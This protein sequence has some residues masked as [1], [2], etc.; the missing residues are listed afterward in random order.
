[1]SLNFFMSKSVVLHSLCLAL[2][3]AG[4]SH[5]SLT[6][7]EPVV[8]SST[9]VAS[10]EKDIDFARDVRPILADACYHCH[11]PDA[12]HREADLRLDHSEGATAD[13]GGY[14]AIVP[15][16]DERS[17]LVSRIM[18]DD[19][20]KVMPP[21]HSGK[22]LDARS[23]EVLRRWIDEGAA[24]STHWAFE[25]P[26]KPPLPSVK[27]LDWP[28]GELDTF[29][30]DRLEREGLTPSPSA[31]RETL[32]RR[33]TLDLTGLPPAPEDVDAFC[34]DP[35]PTAYEREVKRL[36][37]SVHYGERWGRIWL[38]AA[39]YADSDGFEKDKP[40]FV[41]FYR[42]WVVDSLN[43]DLPYDQ[44][45]IKQIAGDLLPNATQG[46]H[47]A[48]GFLRNSMINEEGGVDP[49]QFRMEA[50][51]DRMDAIGKSVLGLTL[52]CAQCHSHKYD[53]LTQVEYYCMFAFL[54]NSHEANI[55][56]YTD[57]EQ[58]RVSDVAQRLALI[59]DEFQAA[60]PRWKTEYESWERSVAPQSTTS[61]KPLEIRFIADSQGGQK[62]IPQGDGSY[63]AQGY[64]PTKST[65]TGDATIHSLK[66]ITG[67][68]I[69]L[70]N[71]P[72]LPHGG[73]GRSVDGTWTLSE[74]DLKVKKNGNWEKV[75]F[76]SASSTINL[77]QRPLAGRYGDKT[78]TERLVGPASFA[79]DGNSNT[80]WHGDMGPGRRNGPQTAMFI[81]AEAIA[82]KD[83][84]PIELRIGLTQNHGGWNSDD[85][86]THNLGRFRVLVCGDKSPTIDAIPPVL[87]D[88]L[89][90]V[91]LRRTKRDADRLLDFW[92]GQMP[93]WKNLAEKM[94]AAWAEHP[95]GTSQLTLVER[96]WPR[97]T[98]RLDRGSFL[99]PKEVV[100]RGTPAFL[101]SIDFQL[102]H[103]DSPSVDQPTATRL[104]FA[105]WLVS[106]KQPTT[107]RSIVN[108]VWQE[109]FGTGLTATSDDLG[110][111]GEP[112]SHP[113]LLDWLAADFMENG[114]SLKHLHQRIVLS[115]TYQQSSFVTPKLLELDPSNRLLARG[116]RRRISAEMVRDVALA[117]SGLLNRTVGGPPI[118]PPAPSFLFQPPASYGPKTWNENTDGNQYR[119]ALYT[120]RFRSVPY[121]VLQA[122]DSPTGEVSCVRRSLSNTPLQALTTLNEPLFLE[123]ARQLAKQSGDQASDKARIESIFRRCVSRYPTNDE[124]KIL[125]TLLNQQRERFAT[126]SEGASK[127]ALGASSQ[128]AADQAAWIALSRV[129]MN[130]DETI[131]K[132]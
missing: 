22:S 6:A 114:W 121:P 1:M 105:K 92:I 108:R 124:L 18:S 9:V 78:D 5:S 3:F 126:D 80:A 29:V 62:F 93:A 42:D 24:Y 115:A 40:R 116:S 53:P 79:I 109:Y 55:T 127:L 34:N 28:Q 10:N 107:A 96:Q 26:V 90:Q 68:R 91:P 98:H 59:R 39:R 60:N 83:D 97:L 64:A 87:R 14:A 130:L 132:E 61:W 65:P 123:C 125:S 119:R 51:Y 52:Q 102:I 101:P 43:R 89:E 100:E 63:L 118:F 73:P 12:E 21:P 84:E 36:L 69:D 20:E 77:P 41:W 50:M 25:S 16:S 30:L 19:A 67:I 113:E 13:R 95:A 47:V 71:D 37:D 46:D 120:F 74:V 45:V 82:S 15:G 66:Q 38:D 86:Q 57:E 44:F 76:A 106:P 81:L 31:S 32:L 11:G 94:E 4:L 110:L 2:G 112:P 58:K 122:F 85:N 8:Q 35:S 49:E 56:V 104:D 129:L 117:A 70:L 23:I 7:N 103:T 27:Q 99:N 88:V 131:T 128:D 54:N 17:E 72:N 75:V 33:L 111:Q 48:T